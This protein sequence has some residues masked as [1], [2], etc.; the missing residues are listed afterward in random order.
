LILNIQTSSI[1]HQTPRNRDRAT[2]GALCF[3]KQKRL[4]IARPV[5][6]AEGIAQI[7]HKKTPTN[8]G[9]IVGL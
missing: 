5:A 6:I 4:A 9:V 8:A 2:V 7:N 1:E 3:E